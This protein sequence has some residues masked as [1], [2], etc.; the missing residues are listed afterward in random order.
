MSE[1]SVIVPVYNTEKY[2]RRCIDS[3]LE[4]LFLDFEL[5]LV[6]DGSTDGSGTICDEYVRK[7]SRVRVFHK[8]N[9]GVSS[10]RNVGLENAVG[11]WVVFVDSDD[12]VKTDY[13]K[14]LL[15]H[16]VE[17]V[18]LVVSFPEVFLQNGSY[19]IEHYS[20]CMI[21]KNNFGQMF[22]SNDLQEH[23]SPWGKLYR[24]SIVK[25]HNIQFDETMTFG[26]DTV[27]LYTFLLYAD[28][29]YI[30]TEI[31]YCYRGEI[32]GSLSKRINPIDWEYVN[33]TK[34]HDAV[35]LLVKQRHIVDNGA[36]G[37]LKAMLA[38]YVW[39]T[40]NSLYHSQVSRNSRLRII[41]SLDMSVLPYKKS[42]C[43]K[44]NIILFMLQHGF[45]KL[46]DLA[47]NVLTRKQTKQK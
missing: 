27:F 45:F 12:W 6:D 35:D 44:D 17:G 41:S 21:N 46:Y 31:G 29:I 24:A 26:E 23:T 19:K 32:E 16:V 30:S 33:Y 38:T 13:L 9:G 14:N 47:R 7:D 25:K 37:K 28:C 20:E 15:S 39:R 3:V 5:L 8:P 36:L 18:D 2:L 11:K 1:V 42:I 10:A 43:F 34:V 40:L 4:Q 22:S